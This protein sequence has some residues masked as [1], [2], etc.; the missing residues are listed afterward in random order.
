M[1][2]CALVLDQ[3]SQ[4][5]KELAKIPSGYSM[6]KRE[7]VLPA[8]ILWLMLW[9]VALY[10]LYV[11][12]ASVGQYFFG[13]A[14]LAACSLASLSRDSWSLFSFSS[15]WMAVIGSEARGYSQEAK[16]L[17][18]SRVSIPMKPGIESLNAAVASGIILFEAARQRAASIDQA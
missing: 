2:V 7:W 1:L 10:L 9:A 6:R 12:T 15:P 5:G 8:V 14:W 11:D 3:L 13:L 17:G 18:A 4:A 16:A